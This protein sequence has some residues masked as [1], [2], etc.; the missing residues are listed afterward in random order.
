MTASSGNAHTRVYLL[1][2]RGYW[3]RYPVRIWKFPG[4]FRVIAVRPGYESLLGGRIVG[5]AG[6]PI[7]TAIAAVRPLF[8]GNDNWAGYMETYTLTSPDALIATHL[9]TG[10]GGAEFVVSKNGRTVSK[11]VEPAPFTYRN[12]PEESWWYLSPEHPAV[13]GWVQVL[14]GHSLPVYLAN[15]SENYRYLKCTGGVSY[16]E[17]TRAENGNGETIKQI[18]SRILADIKKQPP[19]KFIIDLRMNTGGD[20][21]LGHYYLFKPLTGMPIAKERGR[22]FAIVGPTTFSAGITAA[23]WLK[24][25]SSTTFV[26]TAPGD[27]LD[28]WSEG[29]N[30]VLPNSKLTM[31]YGDKAHLYSDKPTTLPKS[32][33]YVDWSVHDLNP[34]LPVKLAWQAYADGRDP[35]LKRILGHPLQCS[36]DRE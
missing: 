30:I 32:E 29:G 3:R 7:A 15:D 33:I 23:V 35:S 27:V 17:F 24:Q 28:T 20:A 22:V 8:A 18:G 16:F 36:P 26:G 19:R 34:D 10:D 25:E 31:H 12:G 14:Q 5:I 2:N 21:T 6:H 4:G 13:K 11:L 1:R 9:L